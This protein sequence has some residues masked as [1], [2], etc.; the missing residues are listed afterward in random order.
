MSFTLDTFCHLPPS[1]QEVAVARLD[2]ALEALND[3]WREGRFTM[4]EIGE[5]ARVCRVSRVMRPY[6][7]SLAGQPR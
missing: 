3:A 1:M 6:L 5:F 4:D 2:E 7:E